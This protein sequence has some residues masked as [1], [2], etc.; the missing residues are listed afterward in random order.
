VRGGVFTLCDRAGISLQGSNNKLIGVHC[1]SN[2]GDGVYA[3]ANTSD[4]ST[5]TGC[6][7]ESNAGY[8]IDI[9]GGDE[10][11]VVV[12]NRMTNNTAGNY[13]DTSGTST[14]VGNDTT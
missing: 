7:F 2:A 5:V 8:G 12:G 9:G 14:F 10:N 1:S 13:R 4:N 6:N 11:L 3:A